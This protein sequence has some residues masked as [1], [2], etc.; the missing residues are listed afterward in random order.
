MYMFVLAACL[1]FSSSMMFDVNLQEMTWAVPSIEILQGK[2]QGFMGVHGIYTKKL[3]LDSRQD[4]KDSR[5]DPKDS[6]QD[7]K[8][9]RQDPNPCAFLKD[10]FLSLDPQERHRCERKVL[11]IYDFRE[12]DES[13]FLWFLWEEHVGKYVLHAVTPCPV[14]V[15]TF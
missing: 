13:K 1:Y 12:G 10:T 6:R 15:T 5:Q 2:H 4:P 8:D 3:R 14:T 7:P 11:W 9:S